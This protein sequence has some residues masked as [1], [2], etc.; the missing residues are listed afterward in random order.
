MDYIIKN[1]EIYDSEL[2]KYFYKDIGIKDGIIQKIDNNIST[3][4]QVIDAKGLTLVPGFIDLHI[5][6]DPMSPE[7]DIR[8]YTQ[9][10]MLN[11]GVTT[12]V[13]GN[14]GFSTKDIGG[15]FAYIDKN[16]SPVNTLLYSGYSEIRSMLSSDT[17]SGNGSSYRLGDVNKTL[18]ASEIQSLIP[19]IRKHMDE[20]ALGLSFGLEYTPGTGT[21]EVISVVKPL[22]DYDKALVSAHYRYDNERCL[23][24]IDEC[25]NI[26]EKTK[27]PF[28]FSHI[29]SCAAFGYMNEALERLSLARDRGIDISVDCYPYDA[30]STLIGST[31]FDD[32][33]LEAWGVGY[34]AIL[35]TE[36]KYKNQYCTKETFDYIREFEPDTRVVCFAMNQEEIN[37]AYKNPNVMVASDG[38]IKDGQ[39]HPRGAGTFPRV[40]GSLVRDQEILT[41]EEAIKKMTLMPANR[42]GF[43]N[44]G[45]IKEGCDA[46]ITILNKDTIIDNAS[47]EDPSL[48][49]T[50]IEYV[51]VNGKLAL[52]KGKAIKL[53]AGKSIRRQD[54][55]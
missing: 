2:G 1:A 13:G 30:F 19:F 41:F 38:K 35:P 55:R 26:A 46:D 10:S 53:N 27:V 36:G 40:L 8:F 49:P 33:C 15:Y 52:E 3:G 47:Y 31:V 21:E 34:D 4:K 45:R 24:S 32:G 44:K 28:L 29:G 7:G 50:G 54:I 9:E 48:A 14:C 12:V 11:M 6:E 22:A 16:G 17:D 20:G 37:L 23:E 42:L 39:G 18:N 5:H 43:K 51:F 25:I